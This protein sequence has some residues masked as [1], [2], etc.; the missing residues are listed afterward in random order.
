[1]NKKIYGNS[2]TTPFSKRKTNEIILEN[3]VQ[4][5]GDSKDKIMSQ[6]AIS[7]LVATRFKSD[8]PVELNVETTHYNTDGTHNSDVARV[9]A[10][11]HVQ[12]G[13]EF[14]LS[15]RI[16]KYGMPGYIFLDNANNI[17]ETGLVGDNTQLI[18]TDYEI[19]AP[20]DAFKLI[21]QSTN[22]YYPPLLKK[23]VYS[24]L[25]IF[26]KKTF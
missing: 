16:G 23:A 9:H 12:P 24:Y 13:E 19:V 18:Y 20:A 6:K 17:L 4:E 11:H 3:I 2:L 21:V 10:I 22:S 15:T 14:K 5:A 7:E 25:P 26:Y 8:E 1:M